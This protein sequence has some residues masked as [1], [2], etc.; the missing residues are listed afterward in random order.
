MIDVSAV[1]VTT[2]VLSVVA[3]LPAATV[4]S[5]LFRLREV[6]LI[7]SGVQHTKGRNTDNGCFDGENLSR[8]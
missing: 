3:V 5:F 8:V 6:K 4:M 2:G 7:G 1:S